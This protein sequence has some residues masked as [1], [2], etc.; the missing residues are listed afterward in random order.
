VTSWT[1]PFAYFDGNA[2]G[3]FSR[4]ST[5]PFVTNPLP[6]ATA[7]RLTSAQEETLVKEHLP[8]VGYLVSEMIGRVP[9]HVSRDDLSSAGLAA[10]AF[11]ARGFDPDRGVPFGRFAS[12]RIRGAL[13]DELR[14]HDWASR[15]VRAKAR[16]RDTASQSL[17]AT[18]GRAPTSGEV[19]ESLG[20]GTGEIDAGE[21]DVQRAVVLSLDGFFDASPLDEMAPIGDVSPEQHVLANERVGY[22]HDAVTVLPERLRSV[23]TQ[24]FFEERP[25]A[26]IAADLQVSESRVSQMRAE[27]LVLLKDG[28]NSA[29]EPA[30]VP[31]AQR[32]DGCANR[33]REAYFAA[34]ASN[35]DYRARLSARPVQMQPALTCSA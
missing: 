7:Q 12:T 10:L 30:L 6:S 25:M 26:D 15:S 24:Y 11:A 16:Q 13:I 17:A 20:L 33:R 34:V 23:V 9:A 1:V 14:S 21:R 27:A 18:L 22:L 19:A 3:H 4:R 28:L 2:S 8:L 35:S 32:A 5:H 31:V 29:L